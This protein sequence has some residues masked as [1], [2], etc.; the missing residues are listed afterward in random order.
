MKK[1]VLFLILFAAALIAAAADQTALLKQTLSK[2]PWFAGKNLTDFQK[3]ELVESSTVKTAIARADKYLTQEFPNPFPDLYL[4]F[5]KTGNRS[6]FQAVYDQYSRAIAML[7]T[8]FYATGKQVYREKLEELIVKVCDFPTWV[9]PAHDK[10]LLNY[11]GKSI[12]IDLAS[13]VTGWRLATVLGLFRNDL[14][15]AVSKRLEQELNRRI[16]VPFDQISLKKRAPFWWMTRKMNW[17]AVCLAGITGTILAVEPDYGK[18]LRMLSTVLE[19]SK[20]FLDSFLADGYCSEGA[21]YWNYG[22]GHYLYMAAM[23]YLATDRNLNLLKQPA[24]RA[25]ASYPNRIVIGGGWLPA[26]ADCNYKTRIAEQYLDLHD[27]LLGQTQK[28]RLL[29]WFPE[30]L[31]PAELCNANAPETERE[32]KLEELSLFPDGAVAVMRPGKMADCRIAAA[33]KGGHNDELHNHNDVG[34]Y[35]IVVD[36]KAP[37][38]GDPGAEVYNAW[39]FGPKRYENPIMNSF[40]HP[41]PRPAGQLQVPGKKTAAILLE[42]KKD[43]NSFLWKLDLR[44]AYRVASMKKLE[45]TFFYSRE[46]RGSFTVTDTVEFSKPESFETAII[47]FGTCKQIAPG[48]LELEFSGRKLIASIDTNGEPFTLQTSGIPGKYQGGLKPQR[49]AIQLK[50]T[51]RK[52]EIRITFTPDQQ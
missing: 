52:A 20:Y 13:A 32:E 10:K 46:N 25:P 40:G 48:K 4:D 23:F 6:R 18:R 5:Q 9:L 11:S 39:T 51:V 50:N 22:F 8:A 45:R 34:S 7:S 37:V 29:G 42:E 3:K 12:E 28:R 15:P 49:I 14:S 1:T 35:T 26:F 33:V 47:A 30:L 36:G 16:L 2:A 38:T 31:L 41:V 19:Y 43:N 44:Q 24:T 21:A 17:N 27:L